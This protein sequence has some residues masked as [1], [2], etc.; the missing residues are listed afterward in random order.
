MYFCV[1][2]CQ[3]KVYKEENKKIFTK[4][5][6]SVPSSLGQLE[7]HINLHKQRKDKF[8][9]A[10]VLTTQSRTI[11]LYKSISKQKTRTHNLVCILYCFQKTARQ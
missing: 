3:N 6:I 8:I 10:I 11:K 9:T 7:Q 2:C 5:K 1:R 4:N